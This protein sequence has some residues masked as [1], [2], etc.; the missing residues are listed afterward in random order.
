MMTQSEA[1]V[2]RPLTRL[3]R[4]QRRSRLAIRG[5]L[6]S[7]VVAATGLISFIAG[8][9]S[10][11]VAFGLPPAPRPAILYAAD[12]TTQLATIRPPNRRVPV[13]ASDIPQV[14]RNAIIAAE[15]ERFLDHSG[16]D[17]KAIMRALLAD[18]S[19]GERQGG[20]TLTQQY[21]KNVYVDDDPTLRRKVQEAGLAFRL[22]QHLSKQQII[23]NY[24]NVIYFGEGNYGVEAASQYY[25]GVS[26]KDLNLDPVTGE[27]SGTLALARA[28]MLAGLVPAPSD[29]N[30]VDSM[31]LAKIRQTYVLT[32]MQINGMISSEVASA[33][34]GVEI[35]PV[36]KVAE[37]QV[38]L[39]PEFTDALKRRLKALYGGNERLGST[40]SE[41]DF[42]GSG[43]RV[44]STLDLRLQEALER[45]MRE[46]LPR[47]TDPQ[48]AAVAVEIGTGNIKAMSTLLR[49]PARV[50]DSGEVVPAVYGYERAG[51]NLASQTYRSTGST[52]KPFIL[53]A[54]LMSGRELDDVVSYPGCDTI[55]IKNADDYRYCNAS[56]EGSSGGS[57]T[58]AGALARSIN[59]VFVPLAIDVGRVKVRRVALKA[60]LLPREPSEA[61]PHPFSAR[62]LSFGLGS[63]AE[64]TTLSLAN[65]FATLMNGGVRHEPRYF[66]EIRE[67]ATATDP[68]TVRAGAAS[69]SKGVRAMPKSIADQVKEAMSKVAT[70]AG[71]APRADQPWTVYGKTG[72]TNSS[73]DARFVGCGKSE[74]GNICLS[75]WLG[76]EYIACDGVDGPCGGMTDLYGFDQVYGGTLPA[77]IFARTFELYRAAERAANAP[78]APVR[79]A[80]PGDADP[81]DADPDR[82]EQSGQPQSPGT[83]S[84]PVTPSQGTDTTE[85][86]EPTDT[87]EPTGPTGPPATTEPP[88]TEEPESPAVPT[89]PPTTRPPGLL[90]ILIPG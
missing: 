39:A 53:A 36:R 88:V 47:R 5:S 74:A 17:V 26:V 70:S 31:R 85:P 58:L 59:T 34:S 73:N 32:R 78:P 8:L 87:T 80:D 35:D 52:L 63:T 43:L 10:V 66:T 37:E 3:Q 16:V 25:F 20:S 14:M 81:G 50:L 18:I 40:T 15:D 44:T 33:A 79:S 4:R 9:L 7:V 30:P 12:G 69:R 29:Y 72:T 65:A 19:G 46:I 82:A 62:P 64:V 57:T 22:E 76:N 45:A 48:A 38:S 27:R 55:P 84:G 2:R 83:P 67:G 56:G 77:I 41:Q 1:G 60:G 13:Q 68:G 54:A 42:Y 71:T 61:F 51:I 86:S 28:A 6:V 21:V 24:L 49:R 23:T 75:I 11:P 89:P 90:D